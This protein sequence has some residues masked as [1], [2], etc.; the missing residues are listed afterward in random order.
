MCN[1]GKGT[2]SE[3][4]K[5]I[6]LRAAHYNGWV[7]PVSLNGISTGALID[8][9]AGSSV[10]SKSVYL[11]M[12]QSARNP[13]TPHPN[14][15]RGIGGMSIQP[16]G[17][18]VVDVEIAGETYPIEMVV[19]CGNETAGCYLGMDFFHTYGC[20]MAVKDGLFT[21]GGQVIPLRRETN[22]AL[23]VQF[24][25][26]VYQDVCMFMLGFLKWVTEVDPFFPLCGRCNV[27]SGRCTCGCRGHLIP[28]RSISAQYFP[29]LVCRR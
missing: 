26:L 7:L 18:M 17:C 9:G 21:I 23:Y 5:S 2:T 11:A 28:H 15:I 6:H 14:S 8:T 12:P 13:L 24:T 1:N 16:L 29:A 4:Q 22:M 27:L 3:S 10:L 20:D 25:V 19:S